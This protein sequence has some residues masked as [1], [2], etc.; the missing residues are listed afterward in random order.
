MKIILKASLSLVYIILKNHMVEIIRLV[1][2]QKPS[3]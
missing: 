1:E 2:N 3:R